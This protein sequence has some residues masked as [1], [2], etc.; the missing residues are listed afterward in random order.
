MINVL[1]WMVGGI[2]LLLSGIHLYWMAGGTRGALAAIPSKGSEL[3][4]RPTPVAT[5]VVAGA[6]ALAGWFVLEL[7]GVAGRQLFPD[8]LF[9]FG[10]WVL[11][12]V[13]IIRAAGD[14]RWVGFFKKQ[15]GTLF[16][17]W[18]TL[19]YSPLCLFLG[20]CFIFLANK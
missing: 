9:G 11:S 17:K 6:L 18:D 1:T 13:F 14:F 20:I 3:L 10:G 4:F 8:W 12:A 16:A 5:G 2:L 19:L 15:Q 7:G